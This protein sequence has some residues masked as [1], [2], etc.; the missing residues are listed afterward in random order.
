MNGHD[1][2]AIN[3][4]DDDLE[5]VVKDI[6]QVVPNH[7]ID[8]ES[9]A[10]TDQL[11]KYTPCLF[12][13]RYDV[14]KALAEVHVEL[15]LIHPFRNGNGRCSRIAASIMALQAGLPVLDFSVISGSKKSDYFR[16]VQVGMD[17]NYKLMEKLFS[18]IIENSIQA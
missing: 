6:A 9:I 2:R 16:A 10:H 7:Y 4:L 8:P 14:I 15:V 3:L 11:E 5:P 1:Y 18:E 13:G 12:Q 17:R